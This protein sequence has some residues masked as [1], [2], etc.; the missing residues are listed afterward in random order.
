M[1]LWS[2]GEMKTGELGMC[3]ITGVVQVVSA[4]EREV[5]VSLHYWKTSREEIEPQKMG[6]FYRGGKRGGGR[7]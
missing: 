7:Q 6:C 2:V 3:G 1:E 5:T 4:A